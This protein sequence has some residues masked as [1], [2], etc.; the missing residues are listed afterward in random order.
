MSH[1][2]PVIAAGGGAHVETVGEDG[3][4]FH[5]GDAEAAANALAALGGDRARRLRIGG[6][7]R[8]R[9]RRLFALPHHLD[10]LELLYREVIRESG[11]RTR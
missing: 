5:P 1:G 2:V 11:R 8:D 9:Q 7:L 3:I 4:L 10:R 6:R